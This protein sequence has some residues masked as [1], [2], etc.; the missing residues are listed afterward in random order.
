MKLESACNAGKDIQF[1]LTISG[2]VADGGSS[3]KNSQLERMCK[4]GRRQLIGSLAQSMCYARIQTC[5]QQTAD[6][7][8]IPLPVLRLCTAG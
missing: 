1:F 4:M 8:V 2:R 6:S 5:T 3:V 7:L